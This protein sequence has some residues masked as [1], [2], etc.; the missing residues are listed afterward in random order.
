MGRVSF[1]DDDG[2]GEVFTFEDVDGHR[3][4]SIGSDAGLSGVWVL[5]GSP[6]IYQGR[7]YYCAGG[8][9]RFRENFATFESV[10][11]IRVELDD[12]TAD[13][14]DEQWKVAERLQRDERRRRAD[15]Q[16][17]EESEKRKPD[18]GDCKKLREGLEEQLRRAGV[19]G[20]SAR[21]MLEEALVRQDCLE[22]S[23]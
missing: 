18:R 10:E 16:R 22:E 9:C 1:C 4:R 15:E 20:D 6:L 11:R 19:V 23:P 3:I 12:E 13:K 21:R 7:L 2:C 14:I 17:D 5:A 8:G